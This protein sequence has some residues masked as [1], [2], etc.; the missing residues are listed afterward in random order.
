LWRAFGLGLGFHALAV[1]E[2]F[3]TLGW[4]H[5]GEAPT[6]SQSV[7]F[8]ALN[9]VQML[10]FKFVPVPRRRGR[11]VDRR[12]RAGA[13]LPAAVGVTLAIVRK[14]RNLFWAAIGF[15]V[16]GPWFSVLGPMA[17]RGPGGSA[18]DRP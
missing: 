11:S 13:G 15:V 10:A 2:V 4:I 6:F 14:V 1:V 8:E 17:G 7:V 3:L 18:T 16:L 9:R 12:A 5:P